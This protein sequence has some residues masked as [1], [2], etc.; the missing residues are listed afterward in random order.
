MKTKII[1]D[2]VI[3]DNEGV[4]LG[5]VGSYVQRVKDVEFKITPAKDYDP[6]EFSVKSKNIYKKP[7]NPNDLPESMDTSN[8]KKVFVYYYMKF[9]NL[10]CDDFDRVGGKIAASINRLYNVSL[11]PVEASKKLEALVT[12][13][14]IL[15]P[16]ESIDPKITS[17]I[18]T[19]KKPLKADLFEGNY[20]FIKDLD[21]LSDQEIDLCKFV[22]PSNL[23][24][25]S[26]ISGFFVAIHP[27][28]KNCFSKLFK[29]TA[30]EQL[31]YD[32]FKD[33]LGDEHKAKK[34]VLMSRI[35]NGTAKVKNTKK[36]APRNKNKGKS[37]SP[38]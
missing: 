21:P 34:L 18:E 28:H 3:S 31:V 24:F 19:A 32:M 36:R 38:S 15:H 10:D 13:A 2:E 26:G 11:S 20:E 14:D 29:F 6:N 1:S 7:S 8:E 25:S 22:D 37:A 23:C 5:S 30:K 33:Q 27:K 12:P 9:G 4:S 16:E 17:N 35:L